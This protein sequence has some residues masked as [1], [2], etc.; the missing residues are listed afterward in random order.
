MEEIIIAGNV[1]TGMEEE[2]EITTPLCH[3]P[4]DVSH[5]RVIDTIQVTEIMKIVK[6]IID[7]LRKVVLVDR[8]RM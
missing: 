1:I 3:P 4:S 7:H 6:I 5:P 8:K 2:K